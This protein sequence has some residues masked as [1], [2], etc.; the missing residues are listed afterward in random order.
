M[1]TTLGAPWLI[2]LNLQR[3]YV[4]PGRPLHAPHGEAVAAV[5]QSCI[6]AARARGWRVSHI[7]TRRPPLANEKFF[8]RPIEGLEPIPSEAVF[9]TAQ[10]SAL[11]HADLC[12]RLREARPD[13]V[14]LI[15][16]SLAHD[17]LATMFHAL[18]IGLPLRVVEGAMGSPALGDR[19]AADID[20]AALAIAA[21]MSALATP[22]EVMGAASATVVRFR[23]GHNDR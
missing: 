20:R 19:S 14:Y 8:A 9:S 6:R 7:Q 23:G 22:E 21:S 3:E 15:G 13:Q 1:K 10:R 4:T 18:D 2:C 11:S 16:F 5:A 17:G 12:A